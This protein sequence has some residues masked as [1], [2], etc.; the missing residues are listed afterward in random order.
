[1][2]RRIALVAAAALSCGACARRA[3]APPKG[4]LVACE[5]PPAGSV[6]AAGVV[7]DTRYPPGSRVVLVSPPFGPGDRRLLSRGLLAAGQPSISPDGRRVVF[8]GKASAEAEWQVYDAS[9]SGAMPVPLTGMA[10]GASSPALLADGTLVLA[11]PVPRAAD[12]WYPARPAAIWAKPSD[13]APAHRLG[14][15]SASVADLSVLADG[16]ILFVSAQPRGSGRSPRLSLFAVN[17]DG[18]GVSAYAC[19]DEGAPVVGRPRELPDGRVAFVASAE[20]L[21]EGSGRAES[22]LSARP[23][24]S[25]SSFLP[26][27]IGSVR[28]VEPGADGTLLVTARRSGTLAETGQFALRRLGPGEELTLEIAA[29]DAGWSIVEAVP[30][31]PRARIPMGRLSTVDPKV[32]TGT[33]L[34]L[35]ANRTSPGDDAT[36]AVKVRIL[37]NGAN[38]SVPLGEVPLSGDG[39]FLAEVP[40][41]VPLGVEAV[42]AA[43]RVVRTLTPWI[44]LRPGENRACIGCHEQRGLAPRNRR[45]LAVK[46]LPV[47]VGGAAALPAGEEGKKPSGGGT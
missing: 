24:K 19:Q 15:G 32:R 4:S 7:L 29:P 1:M 42:D 35:D 28:A 13:G 30:L 16:R 39:S 9:L 20:A 10:G 27:E 43:G 34:C 2:K 37:T 45:P 14:F 18:T 12:G 22:V 46:S 8:A 5:I 17:N 6:P 23:W 38:G 36:P 26:E 3:P 40:A 41:D 21:P 47:P 11:S 44:W 25:R 31:A 33:L